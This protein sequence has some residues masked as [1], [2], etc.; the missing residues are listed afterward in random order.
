MTCNC[1]AD[2]E[3][4][5]LA[6]FKESE[7]DAKEHTV[8]LQGYALILGEKLEQ[9]GCMTIST[10]ADFPLRKGGYKNKKSNMNMIFTYCPFCGVKY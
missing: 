1:K 4:K 2:M 9:K 7:P 8:S 6:R 10:A 5:L 3:S